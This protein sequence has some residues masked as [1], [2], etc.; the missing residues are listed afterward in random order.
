M[1]DKL[2]SV[3]PVYKYLA[4]VGQEDYL[5]EQRLRHSQF[6]HIT[7]L[8]SFKQVFM[9]NFAMLVLEPRKLEPFSSFPGNGCLFKLVN[10]VASGSFAYT[11]TVR[12]ATATLLIVS[13][14][15]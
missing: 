11:I 5:I 14:G 15:S 7:V 4:E 2:Y 9:L 8:H 13:H 12:V 1:A 6:A 10:V 3:L